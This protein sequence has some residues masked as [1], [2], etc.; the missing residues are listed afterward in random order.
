M[1]TFIEGLVNAKLRNMKEMNNVY[2]V[3]HVVKV[4]DYILE[5]SGLENVGFYERVVI[6]NYSVGYVTAT[7]LAFMI[8]VQDSS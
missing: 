3:G 2:E 6:S 1:G 4:K 7:F 8:G 5:V